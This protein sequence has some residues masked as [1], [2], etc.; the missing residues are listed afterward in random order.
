[1]ESLAEL[2]KDVTLESIEAV[3][4]AA[5]QVW[6]MTRQRVLVSNVVGLI[7]NAV[8]AVPLAIIGILCIKYFG[9]DDL[10]PTLSA[11][12]IL[13]AI[14]VFSFTLLSNYIVNLYTLDYATMEKIIGLMSRL[15]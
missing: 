6:A 5:P 12:I 1:M 14:I 11:L 13:T 3:K 2:L 8:F 4:T 9:K 15:R 10:G 7:I